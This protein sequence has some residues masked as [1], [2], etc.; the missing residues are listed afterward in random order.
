MKSMNETGINSEIDLEVAEE[1]LK[2]E[3]ASSEL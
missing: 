3:S 1:P 2:G